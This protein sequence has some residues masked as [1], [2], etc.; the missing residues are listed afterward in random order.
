MHLILS[1]IL[2]K[3]GFLNNCHYGFRKGLDTTDSLLVLVVRK[4]RT[5]LTF[6]NLSKTVYTVNID[7][8]LDKLDLIGV[9]GSVKQ[10]FHS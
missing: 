2:E 10:W 7:I 5:L 3:V 9:R 1:K 6:Q 4:M 8:L